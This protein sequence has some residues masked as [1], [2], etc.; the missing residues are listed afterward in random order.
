MK[1]SF[2]I[3]APL[4]VAAILGVAVQLVRRAAAA[5]AQIPAAT[6]ETRQAASESR[7]IEV[8][9]EPIGPPRRTRVAIRVPG[10]D[11]DRTSVPK[12]APEWIWLAH[13]P[14]FETITSP[15]ALDGLGPVLVLRH[16]LAE[17]QWASV[18]GQDGK[19][20]ILVRYEIVDAESLQLPCPFPE[21]AQ[22]KKGGDYL[23]TAI[24]YWADLA[25]EDRASP[26][27]TYM[28]FKMHK[29]R[30]P[31]QAAFLAQVGPALARVR[32]QWMVY[33]VRP[34]GGLRLQQF[35]GRQRVASGEEGWVVE[36]PP[37]LS[38]EGISRCGQADNI[39]PVYDLSISRPEP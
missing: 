11:M 8:W 35:K 20:P 22:Q 19:G 36:E 2:L 38:G 30:P 7:G 32:A 3:V 33:G 1:R 14:P 17:K 24:L 10:L 31:G 13:E 25:P 23:V 37:R 9:D 12:G 16:Y 29:S 15:C 21:L 34:K 18:T 28:E 4:L 27:A 6:Q 26:L 5:R 39:V